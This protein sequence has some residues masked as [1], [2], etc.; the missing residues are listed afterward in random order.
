[1]TAAMATTLTRTVRRRLLTLRRTI[2]KKTTVRIPPAKKATMLAAENR[3]CTVGFTCLSDARNPAVIA[4]LKAEAHV[5]SRSKS[6]ASFELLANAGNL[7]PF[8]GH[9]I[10][11]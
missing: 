10:T 11:D 8:T 1:M 4:M 6:R 7:L 9:H 5:A 3:N 2:R